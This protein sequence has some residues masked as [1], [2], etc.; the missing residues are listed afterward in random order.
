MPACWVLDSRKLVMS[1]APPSEVDPIAAIYE[2]DE[3]R[4][5][6]DDALALERQPFGA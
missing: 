3:T 2:I 5:L 6:I 1:P 4:R